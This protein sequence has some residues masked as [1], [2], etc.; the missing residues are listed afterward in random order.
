MRRRFSY[1]YI[2]LLGGLLLSSGIYISSLKPKTPNA[3]E[4]IGTSPISE[5]PVASIIPTQTPSEANLTLEI[6]GATIT[7]GES[8]E[9]VLKKLGAP[10]RI[11]DTEYDFDYYI[12]NNDYRRLLFVAIKDK[13]VVGF[14]SDSLDF[15]FQGIHS[16]STL[17]EV[18]S[19]FGKSFSMEDV[20]THTIDDYTVNILMDQQ[21]TQAVTG[22]YI[23]SNSVALE[24]YTEE[25]LSN[26]ELTIYDLTNSARAR[27][28]EAVLSWS[29]SA[30]IS[31]RKHCVN[32]AENDFL[33][34]VD[35]A[36]RKP[37]ERM[38]AEGIYYRTFGENIIAGYDSAI[39]SHHGWYNS[40]KHRINILSPNFRY[41]GV[42]FAYAP[43]ST[44]KTYITQNFYR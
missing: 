27:N 39:L 17:D 8:E 19:A 38:M 44:Y 9:N 37:E 6:R 29:S 42:G 33:S 12:Y 25:V 41:L 1:K 20:L 7:L 3:N 21:E 24:E 28:D 4:A 26:I 5:A 36:G 2:L 18:G 43:D 10:G 16:G 13:A 22:I 31:A 15:N 23:L 30:A 35:P 40:T 32:M 34:H 14:Y 11:D